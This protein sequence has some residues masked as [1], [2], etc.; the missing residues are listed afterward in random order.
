MDIELQ[1]LYQVLNRYGYPAG[2]HDT[3]PAVFTSQEEADE[4]IKYLEDIVDAGTGPYTT[5]PVY[6]CIPS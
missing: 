5:R 6:L 4:W 3:D 2:K 1:D